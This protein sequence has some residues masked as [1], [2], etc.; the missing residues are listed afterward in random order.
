MTGGGLFLSID[1]EDFAHDLKRDLGLW[2]T[3]PLRLDAL[4]RCYEIIDRFLAGYSARATFF[5]TGVIADQA[6]DLVRR[7]AADGH[8]V[9]CHYHFHD[10]MDRQE[11]SETARSL[12]RA[13]A[14][15]E[16]AA[17]TPVLG[18]R[19]PKFR[20]RKDDPAQYREVE[21]LFAYDSSLCVATKAE[22][23]AFRGRM[24]LTSLHILPIYSA[25]PTRSF[26][27][28][29]LGGTYL[30]LFPRVLTDRLITGAE[31]E[32]MVPHI[33]L[34]PYEFA[35]E[36]EFLLSRNELS[37]LGQRK[38]AYWRLRQHQWN[39]VGNRSLL[40]KLKKICDSR[41]PRGR[42]CDHL[43]ELAVA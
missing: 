14:A 10:E 32:G 22:V 39:T 37:G 20:I 7:I 11:T 35:S 13:K 6:P 2:D 42:L 33:Y 24:G 28:L 31:A 23:T 8:E 18:F 34:H 25:P 4:W 30:K 17:N 36:G 27:A 21:R 9:A 40:T 1:F 19:A 38:A 41:P 16:T 12:A 5:C 26:P 3:G 15:L 29:N 43:S